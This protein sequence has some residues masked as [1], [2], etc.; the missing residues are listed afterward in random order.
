MPKSPPGNSGKKPSEDFRQ[1]V[2]N[3]S[4]PQLKLKMELALKDVAMRFPPNTGVL[5]F[6]FEYGEGGG[7]AYCANANRADCIKFLEEWIAY[8]RTLA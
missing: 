1:P 8:Q 2:R 3:L 7:S 4:G 6:A 5:V